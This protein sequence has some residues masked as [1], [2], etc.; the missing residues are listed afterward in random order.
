MNETQQKYYLITDDEF[1]IFE[2]RDLLMEELNDDYYD[3]NSDIHIIYGKELKFKIE[4]KL[5]EI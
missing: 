4:R 5:E 2:D 3:N 1:K